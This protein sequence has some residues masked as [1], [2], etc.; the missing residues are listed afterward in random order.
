[1][2]IKN[3]IHN[4]LGGEGNAQ[5]KVKNIA[6]KVVQISKEIARVLTQVFF[7]TAVNT[8]S[9]IKVTGIA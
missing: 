8:K 3:N 1:M 6:S 5:S 4:V 2:P 7:Q 9:K